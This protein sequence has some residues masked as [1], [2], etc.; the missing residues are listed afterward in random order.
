MKEKGG[1]NV[2]LRLHLTG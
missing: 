1:R 2:M